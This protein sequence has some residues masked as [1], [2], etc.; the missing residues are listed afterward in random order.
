[1]YIIGCIYFIYT[2]TEKMASIKAQ[3]MEMSWEIHIHMN[4]EI[5]YVVAAIY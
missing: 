3:S 1:M 4:V 2:I 5:C